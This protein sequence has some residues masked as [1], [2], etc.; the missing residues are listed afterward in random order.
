[1]FYNIPQSV[2][3]TNIDKDLTAKLKVEKGAI[4]SNQK[5]N[6]VTDILLNF[7]SLIFSVSTISFSVSYHLARSGATSGNV[8]LD[9]VSR[10]KK[11]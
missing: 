9:P 10:R 5:S 2:L 11:T 1:M 8:D 6:F 4:Y 7:F 3:F